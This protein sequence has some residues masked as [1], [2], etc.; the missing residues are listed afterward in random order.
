MSEKQQDG[1]G[2]GENAVAI[3]VGQAQNLREV[4]SLLLI[5]GEISI[6]SFNLFVSSIFFTFS[7]HSPS[8]LRRT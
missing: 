6:F 3:D 1:S 7:I 2:E 8:K 5:R 4:F